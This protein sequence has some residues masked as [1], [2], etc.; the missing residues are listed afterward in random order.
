MHFRRCLKLFLKLN[1]ITLK[2]FCVL[3]ILSFFI[4][5][6][7]DAYTW[8]RIRNHHTGL[9]L[10]R[11]GMY[12]FGYI[13]NALTMQSYDGSSDQLWRFERIESGSYSG[14]YIIINRSSNGNLAGLGVM[15]ASSSN[16][17]E[18]SAWQIDP[19]NA[20]SNAILMTNH[21]PLNVY[22]THVDVSLNGFSRPDDFPAMYSMV[23]PGIFAHPDMYRWYIEAVF[24]DVDPAP[25]PT[26]TPQPTPPPPPPA[27][28]TIID[29]TSFYGIRATSGDYALEIFNSEKAAATNVQGGKYFAPANQIWQLVEYEA[30]SPY[31]YIQNANSS[32]VLQAHTAGNIIQANQAGL[33]EQLWQVEA[34]EGGSFQF[35]NKANGQLL[36]LDSSAEGF[37]PNLITSAPNGDLTQ[38]FIMEPFEQV[39]V[40]FGNYQIYHANRI[41]GVENGP[42]DG[43]DVRGVPI[44]YP[45]PDLVDPIQEPWR[46]IPTT[47]GYH[48]IIGRDFGELLAVDTVVDPEAP[49]KFEVISE[50]QTLADHQQWKFDRQE[51]GTYRITSRDGKL[52]GYTGLEGQDICATQGEITGVSYNW[53]ICQ[54]RHFIGLYEIVNVATGRHMALSFN[55]DENG[56]DVIAWPDFDAVNQQWAIE[57]RNGS[58][59][60]LINLFSLKALDLRGASIEEGT[61]VQQFDSMG[62]PNQQWAVMPVDHETYKIISKLS[63]LALTV[64]RDDELPSNPITQRNYTGDETQHWRLIPV[65]QPV[66]FAR[67]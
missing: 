16:I 5:S 1:L 19:F 31:I 32:L 42:A 61:P 50:P 64:D 9:V 20:E 60:T 29:L 46:I 55:S 35:T 17:D 3:G 10:D 6:M 4:V 49:G 62:T 56:L 66:F 34:S 30:D 21:I 27:A 38:A 51:D 63:N 59:Y 65:Y 67:E 14:S 52:L 15:V 43:L 36:S 39:P 48:V 23:N 11:T 40:F 25:G 41:L 47:D 53:T 57:N 44:N 33:D 24:T 54:T 58:D 26:P 13:T 2:R 7:S 22:L 18:T 45:A 8:Y 28:N 37:T 12:F